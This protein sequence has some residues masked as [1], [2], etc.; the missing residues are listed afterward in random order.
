M[1]SLYGSDAIGGVINIITK[2][3]IKPKLVPSLT[4]G[5]DSLVSGG[6]T[7]TIKKVIFQLLLTLMLFIPM[8][9][10]LL[11]KSA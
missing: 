8:V 9:M 7:Q 2:T 1:S 3:A 11:K 6:I 10:P 4:G 5:T